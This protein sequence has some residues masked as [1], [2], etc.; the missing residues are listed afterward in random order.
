MSLKGNENIQKL[1]IVKSAQL[2]E[3]TIF[4]NM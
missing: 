1:A 3:H 4:S 2:F